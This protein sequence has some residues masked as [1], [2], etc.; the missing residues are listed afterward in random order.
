MLNGAGTSTD[1]A[2]NDGVL[3]ALMQTR[4]PLRGRKKEERGMGERMRM[5]RG[6]IG[7]NGCERGSREQHGDGFRMR[8]HQPEIADPSQA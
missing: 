3:Q 5:I 6:P 8:D 4:T 7:I 1:C 2:S